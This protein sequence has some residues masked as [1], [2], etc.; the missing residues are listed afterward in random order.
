MFPGHAQQHIIG[1]VHDCQQVHIVNPKQHDDVD[2]DDDDEEGEEEEEEDT[3]H[4]SK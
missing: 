4:M 3:K 1:K 2:D